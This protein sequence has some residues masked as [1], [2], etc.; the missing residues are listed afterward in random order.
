MTDVFLSYARED[1]ERAEILARA[2]EARGWTVWWDRR[3]VAGQAFDVAIERELEAARSIVVLWSRL[4]TTS[5]WVKN[6]A[7]FASERG[8]LVPVLIDDVKLPLEF[9]RRQTVQLVDW[10]G[11][12]SDQGF[13]AL[14]DGIESTLGRGAQ[15]TP[16]SAHVPTS[17]RR[18]RKTW[19][20]L[21]AIVVVLGLGLFAMAPWRAFTPQHPSRAERAV[22]ETSARGTQTSAPVTELADLVV[23]TYSGAVIADSKGG[24]RSDVGVTIVKLDPSTVRVTS[25]YRRLGSADI[26]L[27]RIGNQIVS[28]EGDT[29]FI[30]DLDRNPPTLVFDPRSE[31]AYR[32][33]KQR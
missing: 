6:E 27:T 26:A 7:A 18:S 2:F 17:R 33:T 30:V 29:P 9:R 22:V 19:A 16:R 25:S 24:S 32:G 14:C 4:S 31:V 12:P 1:R 8:V 3:I 21:A 28:A 23:G 11:D 10:H 13:Q 5:E 20:V 15:P